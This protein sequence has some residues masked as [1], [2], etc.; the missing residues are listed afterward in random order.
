MS[1][2]QLKIRRMQT[3]EELVAE[4]DSIDDAKQWLAQRP[5]FVEVVRVMSRLDE[6]TEAELRDA[7]RTLD[8]DERAWREQADARQEAERRAELQRMQA[9]ALAAEAA[10]GPGDDPSRP[11]ELAWK[12]GEGLRRVDPDDDREISEASRRVVAHWLRERD[13]WM[14]ERR[15]HVA[16][17]TLRVWPASV[18]GGNESDRILEADFA[19]MPGFSDIEIE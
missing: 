7:M 5:P 1:K 11:M 18:P 15:Q 14:H 13:G 3:G 19:A 2:V 9:E 6:A 16:A 17:A 10:A 4:L 8:D 12:R